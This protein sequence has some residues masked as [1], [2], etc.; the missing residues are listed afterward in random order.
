[1]CPSHLT[2]AQKLLL[3]NHAGSARLVWGTNCNQHLLPETLRS[4]YWATSGVPC[5]CMFDSNARWAA[6]IITTTFLEEL[7]SYMMRADYISSFKSTS[8]RAFLR[9]AQFWDAHTTRN[10]LMSVFKGSW[11]WCRFIQCTWPCHAYLCSEIS[12]QLTSSCLRCSRPSSVSKRG[13]GGSWLC[14]ALL[15]LGL[16]S[17]S[18]QRGPGARLHLIPVPRS[19]VCE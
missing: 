15:E 10:R 19:H 7:F 13:Q 3:V 6:K 16:G 4:Y 12:S 17:S 2:T 1:M 5:G 14:T 9:P 18:W 8:C 11:Y